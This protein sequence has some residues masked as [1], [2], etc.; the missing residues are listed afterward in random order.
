MADISFPTLS[1]GSVAVLRWTLIAPAQSFRSPFDGTLQTGSTQG[2]RWEASLSLRPM[3][4]ADAVEL[5]AMLAK[6]RGQ[7]NRLLV[8][9]FGRSV[10]R[11]TIN[12]SGVT[13]NGAVSAGASQAN[14]T[15]CGAAKTLKTGDLFSVAGELKMVVDGP[16]TA[17][18]SGNMA[19]VKFE[20]PSRADW[21]SGAAVTLS[22]PTCTMVQK[23][24]GTGWT[25]RQPV[26][27]EFDAIE[28][29]EAFS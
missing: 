16:Y 12:T 1:R 28:L 3:T 8:P 15:G 24:S 21:L 4:E 18:G 2:P 19:S 26:I 25:T 7:A 13:L 5:Q 14:L 23:S 10:P 22:S 9:Y 27:T 20:P 17:D 6:L 11:G 29:E